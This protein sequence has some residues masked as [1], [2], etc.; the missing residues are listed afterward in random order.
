MRYWEPW[1][2]HEWIPHGGYLQ[3]ASFPTTVLT[4]SG[5]RV[6]ELSQ[7]Q[8][9]H[10]GPPKRIC[11]AVEIIVAGF[12][13]FVNTGSGSGGV[14]QAGS[15]SRDGFRRIRNRSGQSLRPVGPLGTSLCTREA[16]ALLR[17]CK[18]KKSPT[19]APTFLRLSS[20]GHSPKGVGHGT[21]RQNIKGRPHC[22]PALCLLSSPGYPP[23]GVGHGTS[24]QSV[25]GRAHCTPLIN[26]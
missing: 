4:V 15:Q 8:P 11:F 25:R 16:Q 12:P 17:Q 3:C 21:S 18:N 14:V 1:A 22:S 10:S 20:P 9:V 6:R 13:G 5:S 7:S 19:E 26:N 24:H 23:S 2:I